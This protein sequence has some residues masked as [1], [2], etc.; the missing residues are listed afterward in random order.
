[1]CPK[2]LTDIRKL[3]ADRSMQLQQHNKFGSANVVTEEASWHLPESEE[4]LADNINFADQDIFEVATSD[5]EIQ[6][7]DSD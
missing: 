3:E 6:E 7:N 5:L 4:I 1:M 2:W